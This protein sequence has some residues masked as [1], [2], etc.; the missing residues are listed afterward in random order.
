[1]SKDDAGCGT[2]GRVLTC[3]CDTSLEAQDKRISE[4]EAAL[5]MQAK[6]RIAEYQRLLTDSADLLVENERLQRELAEERVKHA[7]TLQHVLSGTSGKA[8]S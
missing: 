2:C 8:L 1:M 7:L 3:R 6:S 5:E 4:L